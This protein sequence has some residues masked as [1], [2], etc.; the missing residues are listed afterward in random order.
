MHLA[1]PSVSVLRHS[2]VLGIQGKRRSIEKRVTPG[3]G[4]GGWQAKMR[5]PAFDYAGCDVGF[6]ERD[7]DDWDPVAAGIAWGRSVRALREAFGAGSAVAPVELEGAWDEHI[8]MLFSPPPPAQNGQAN[9]GGGGG[10]GAAAVSQKTLNALIATFT[11]VPVPT[12]VLVPT[13]A[14]ATAPSGTSALSTFLTTHFLPHRPPS[15]A[16]RLLH[17]TL[18]A[19]QIVDEV[20]LSF[21][22]SCAMPWI[23]PGVPPT[24]KKVEVALVVSAELRQGG[25]V[26]AERWYWDQGSVLVQIG[27]VDVLEGVARG[28]KRGAGGGGKGKKGKGKGRAGRGADA[29]VV[30]ELPVAGAEAAR[31]LRE[32]GRWRELENEMLEL[33]LSDGEAE[34]EK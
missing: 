13:L 17:R 14:G 8:G 6:A 30:E 12:L 15:L 24:G 5:Y 29:G 26:C 27:V 1:G 31:R 21:T 3:S 2:E 4:W 23:L 11:S 33:G 28:W 22:H 20:L 16:T 10:G 32:P 34:A 19:T 7:L 25:K 18:S 9:G